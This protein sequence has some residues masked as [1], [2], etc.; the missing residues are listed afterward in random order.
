MESKIP[1][2]FDWPKVVGGTNLS[3]SKKPQGSRKNIETI[4]KSLKI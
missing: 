3:N 2:K 1:L 4:L